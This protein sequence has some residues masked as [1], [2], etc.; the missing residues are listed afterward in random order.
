MAKTKDRILTAALSLFNEKGLVNVRLQHIA[1]ACSISVGNLAYHYYSKES[2][3]IAII[4]ELNKEMSH[5]LANYTAVPLFEH[6]DNIL[7]QNFYLQQCYKFFFLDTL[8]IYR[9]FDKV[10]SLS[11]KYFQQQVIQIEGMFIFNVARGAFVKGKDYNLLAKTF[12]MMGHFWMYEQE[13]FESES[14]FL[15]DYKKQMWQLLM[16]YCTELGMLEFQ[17]LQQKFVD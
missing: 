2:I 4:K 16:P 11:R 12:W 8:E 3:V 5:V 13:L 17:G 15:K 10:K 6:I 14:H 1:D 7:E 9:N